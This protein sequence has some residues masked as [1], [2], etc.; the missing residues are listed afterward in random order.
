MATLPVYPLSA[1]TTNTNPTTPLGR[2]SRELLNFPSGPTIGV[3]NEIS[4]VRTNWEVGTQLNTRASSALIEDAQAFSI[5]AR[6]YNINDP[7]FLL[8]NVRLT[9]MPGLTHEE[10]VIVTEY[11]LR[12]T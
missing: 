4:V 6:F 12:N 3:S 10:R 1:V 11:L 8:S 5:I 9:Q 7:G 2:P